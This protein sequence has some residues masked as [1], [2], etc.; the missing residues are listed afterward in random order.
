MSM[1][2]RPRASQYGQHF[3]VATGH[4]LATRAAAAQL[5][6]GG[7]LTD[8]MIAASAV[9][10]VVLPHATALGGCAMMLTHDAASGRV[11]ALN[12]SGIAPAQ[13]GPARF[14]A[15]IDPRGPRSWVVPGLVRFW[16]QAHRVQ[17]RLPWRSLFEPAIALADSGAPF[18][19]ELARNL[20]MATAQVRCQPGFSEAF[21]ADGED[22][23]A[24]SI[25]RQPAL[26]ETL[27]LIARYGEDGFYEGPVAEKLLRFSAASGGLLQADDLRR[28]Q[29][30]WCEPVYQDYGAFGA[31]VMP[32]NSVGV[33]MLAQLHRLRAGFGEQRDARL[34]AQI[35][36]A[37]ACLPTLHDRVADTSAQWPWS[38]RDEDASHTL[39]AAGRGDPG[40]T[41][42]IVLADGK[43]NGLVMLQSVFQPFGSGCIDPS[44]G[45]LM[46]N[47]L[48]EFSLDPSRHNCLAPGKRPVH[49]LNPYIAFQDGRPTLFAVSPGGVSQT[50]TGVQLISN[51]LIDRMRLPAAIDMARWS[52]SRDGQVM[53][54]P[55]FA[56]AAIECLR[57]AGVDVATDSLHPFYFGSIKAVRVCT[58]GI[59]EAA[60]DL[61]REATAAAW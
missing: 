44:S 52:L 11:R 57:A 13:A 49:T 48:S 50:T 14:G 36:Q 27:G 59:L 9:L 1:P 51:V 8:A 7:S 61:R 39:A 26:A 21:L 46:N 45:V 55:G 58:P 19:S 6:R 15:A 23:A 25:W 28:V 18:S 33:L 22:R 17:G 29:A 60:A 10:T 3:G 4:H 16:A 41:A 47:R 5:E 32:P 34:A 42:G 35:A 24:G 31:A 40:D 37:R 53:C 2:L 20:Q 38:W 30:D 43:G 54:E 56:T 12:G